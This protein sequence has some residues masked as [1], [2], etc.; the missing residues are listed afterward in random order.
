LRGN[1]TDRLF[2]G[3]P[4]PHATRK[5]LHAITL[6]DAFYRDADSHPDH[7]AFIAGEAVRTK[8]RLAAEI[9]GIPDAVLGQRVGGWQNS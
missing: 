3:L 1:A 4:S 8:Q 2:S 7:V 9:V 5:K 6:V